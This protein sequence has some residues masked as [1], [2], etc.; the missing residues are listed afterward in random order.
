MADRCWHPNC[1]LCIVSTWR[2]TSKLCILETINV[3]MSCKVLYVLV[4][5][6]NSLKMSFIGI[7][8]F[9]YEHPSILLTTG[10]WHRKSQVLIPHY[11]S[12]KWISLVIYAVLSEQDMIEGDKLGFRV[13][14]ILLSHLG[15]DCLL[16]IHWY[17]EK[18]RSVY[19][20]VL[21]SLRTAKQRGVAL[22]WALLPLAKTSDM[23]LGHL[24]SETTGTLLK[25][26]SHTTVLLWILSVNWRR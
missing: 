18:Y 2:N 24:F 19:T 20:P 15:I 11:S 4:H 22:S 1:I 16:C 17:R 26:N 9:F 7:L 10:I 13:R 5:V 23:S 21:A 8:F 14:L 12:L 6:L 3:H 25:V